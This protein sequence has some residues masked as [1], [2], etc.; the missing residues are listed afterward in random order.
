MQSMICE[1]VCG[2]LVPNGCDC[3][4]CCE[5]FTPVGGSVTVYLGSA[6]AAGDATCTMDVLED[7]ALCAP[8]TQVQACLNDCSG[9]EL[10]FGMTELPPGCVV[11]ECEGE[12]QAC[13]QPGQDPCP[14]G[15]FCLTGCCVAD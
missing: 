12:Q 1:D 2:P 14:V 10:C 3:F 11:Q 8:C 7:P 4:G 6:N 13:G 9:C 5:V 15:S